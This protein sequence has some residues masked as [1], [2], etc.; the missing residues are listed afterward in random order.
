MIGILKKVLQTKLSLMNQLLGFFAVFSVYL[1]EIISALYLSTTNKMLPALVVI[2]FQIIGYGV[3]GVFFYF[4]IKK[5][6]PIDSYAF[7]DSSIDH[8]STNQDVTKKEGKGSLIT[9]IMNIFLG[10]GIMNLFKYAVPLLI[11]VDKDVMFFVAIV[12]IVLAIMLLNIFMVISWLIVHNKTDYDQYLYFF[13][14]GFKVY[15]GSLK[16]IMMSFLTVIIIGL[17]MTLLTLWVWPSLSET[18]FSPIFIIFIKYT[19]NA[20]LIAAMLLFLVRLMTVI[21]ENEFEYATTKKTPISYMLSALFLFFAVA[22]LIPTSVNIIEKEYETIITKA[23]DYRSEGKLYLCGN[24]YKKA[25]AL[26]QAYSGYLMQIQTQKD[27]KATEAQITRVKGEADVLFRK[28]YEFYPNSDKIY[29]LDALRYKEQSITQAVTALQ[30]AKKYNTNFREADLLLLEVSNEMDNAELSR[31]TADVLITNE[32]FVKVGTLND[33]SR[34][35]MEKESE[36]I[37]AYNKVCL[38]NITTIAYDYYNNKLFDEAMIE[39]Q[40]IQEILPKDVVTNYLIAMT[41]LELKSDNKQYTT[42]IEAAQTILEQ[43]PNEPWAQELYSGVT[44]RAGNQNVMDVA[45]KEAYEKNPNNLDIA[46]Q[47]AYSILKKNYASS[48]YEV[49]EQAEIVVDEILAK[50]GERWFALYCQSLIQLY[51]GEYENSMISFNQFGNLIIEDMDLFDMYDELFNT[52][53]IKYAN[54]MVMDPVAIEILDTSDSVD[55]FTY[56]YTMGAYGTM[57]GQNDQEATITFLADALDY[58][59][60]FSKLY[61]MIGNAYME[62]GY[63]NDDRESYSSAEDYYI[64]SLQLLPNDP[65][66]WFALGHAYKNQESYEDAMGAFQK[67]LDLM[68]A[69]DHQSDHFGVSIHAYHQLAEIQGVIAAKEGQ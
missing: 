42:A 20:C 69:E 45:L 52:Y 55:A 63:M 54:R 65:Y 30:N 21:Y 67:T 25:Y 10:I 35:K 66:A 23:E 46:E 34:N 43:Y 59:P 49:T 9:T 1:G 53:V 17:L 13:F 51:K 36:Q 50:D 47:Y 29:Y 62:I 39:L 58:N 22:I 57:N 6:K 15:L 48:Y 28:A 18:T 44:L 27:K 24:E 40:M 60:N 33:M 11:G 68:P 41:D 61:Y 8:E 32:V 26:I 38:E 14:K 4:A 16:F 19:G 31:L 12:L 37:E 5:V 64:E 2:I 3:A 56:S 7:I